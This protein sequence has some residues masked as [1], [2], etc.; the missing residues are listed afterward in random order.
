MLNLNFARLAENMADVAYRFPI[1]IPPYWSLVIRCLTILEGI[2]LEYNPKF[3]VRENGRVT[4]AVT[5][6]EGLGSDVTLWVAVIQVV[7]GV[8]PFILKYLLKVR[9]GRL[10]IPTS[11]CSE[12]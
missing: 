4:V 10:L 7:T 9:G 1:R 12:S 11:A 3:K 5:S 2:A 8:Y 6:I